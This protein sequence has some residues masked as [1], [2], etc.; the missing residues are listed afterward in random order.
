MRAG[1]GA[2]LLPQNEKRKKTKKE[3]NRKEKTKREGKRQYRSRRREGEG[4]NV[5][6]RWGQ[7]ML[8]PAC[9]GSVFNT[10]QCTQCIEVHAVHCSSLRSNSAP[11]GPA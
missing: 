8:Q 3:R 11:T 9:P 6:G 2:G 7:P 4:R 10:A 5:Q 1:E